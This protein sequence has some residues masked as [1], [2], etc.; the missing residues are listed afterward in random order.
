MKHLLSTV[1][2]LSLLFAAN[3]AAAASKGTSLRCAGTLT[4]AFSPAFTLCLPLSYY[5]D[6]FVIN[7]DDILV[8]READS[9]FFGKI[10]TPAQHALPA[11]FDM[12]A[13]PRLL[14]G[15]APLDEWPPAV[16]RSIETARLA[17]FGSAAAPRPLVRADESR[18]LY[19]VELGSRSFVFVVKAE[20]SGQL[21]Y[22][23][24]DG[25]GLDARED[26]L[27]A[28]R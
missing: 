5:R 14:L 4:L 2:S 3:P 28:L 7:A 18:V 13:Y 24:F 19:L 22:L 15:Q 8:K 25:V 21:L 23:G 17:L 12:R 20:Q 26:V 10:V 9:F 6:A 16:V 11:N 1:L 27:E